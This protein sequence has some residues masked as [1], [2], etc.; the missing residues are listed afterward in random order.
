MAVELIEK[1]YDRKEVYFCIHD[2]TLQATRNATDHLH[3]DFKAANDSVK[4]LEQF[5]V[6]QEHPKILARFGREVL[7]SI[8]GAE[9]EIGAYKRRDNF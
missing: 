3:I 8:F 4:R 2:K 9:Y 7:P 1:R 5:K 6:M